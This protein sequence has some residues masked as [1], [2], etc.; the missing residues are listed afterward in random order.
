MPLLSP[1]ILG[2]IGALI[3]GPILTAIF[4]EILQY[5]FTKSLRIILISFT[6][7]TIVAFVSLILL[8]QL[9]PPEAI[10]R[11]LSLVGAAILIWI[12]SS[13]YKVRSLHTGEKTFFT[14]GKIIAMILANGVLWTYW[15]TVC[16]PK[17]IELGH[18]IPYGQYLFVAI[19][20]LT[21]LPVTTGVAFIFSRFRGV[22]SNP[23]VVP[24]MFKIFA[25]TFVYF[26]VSMVWESV[27]FFMG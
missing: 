14:S 22:L 18:T 12:A 7:E 5:N 15:I 9:N 21:W 2:L 19:A 17:A 11:A 25:G 20:Q 10:F 16:I 23:R 1:F 13:I 8:Q 26:A 4:T 27:R 6:T 24:V 3:P